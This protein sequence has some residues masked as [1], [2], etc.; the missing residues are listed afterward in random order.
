MCYLCIGLCYLRIWFGARDM[1]WFSK[2]LVAAFSSLEFLSSLKLW[3]TQAGM[4]SLLML[5]HIKMNGGQLLSLFSLLQVSNTS[6]SPHLPE[7]NC[8]MTDNTHI[9]S[10]VQAL[11]IWALMKPEH[12]PS[13]SFLRFPNSQVFNVFCIGTCFFVFREIIVNALPSI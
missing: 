3:N 8:Q 12:F 10:K 6:C 1:G 9:A 5:G 13:L 2:F 7:S 11:M 4:T